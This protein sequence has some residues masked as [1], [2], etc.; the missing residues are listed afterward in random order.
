MRDSKDENRVNEELIEGDG[1]DVQ[2]QFVFSNL[3]CIM[4]TL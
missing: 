1:S 2:L 3:L 4:V